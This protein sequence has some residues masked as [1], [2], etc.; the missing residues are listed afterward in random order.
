MV[1]LNFVAMMSGDPINLFV[2]VTEN[3]GFPRDRRMLSKTKLI[4]FVF[5]DM[6]TYFSIMNI[7]IRKFKFNSAEDVALLAIK[8]TYSYAAHI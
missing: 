2:A 3:Y 6:K 7:E 1:Y 4:A 8:I 5:S